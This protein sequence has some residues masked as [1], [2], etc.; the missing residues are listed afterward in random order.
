LRR[1]F[2]H[3]AQHLIE[4]IKPGTLELIVRRIQF[5]RRTQHGTALSAVRHV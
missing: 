2:Q 4:R 3:A 1:L 5:G